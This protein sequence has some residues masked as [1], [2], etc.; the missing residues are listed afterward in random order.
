M[1][2]ASLAAGMAAPRRWTVR[3]AFAI[4]ICPSSSAALAQPATVTRNVNLR[5]DPSTEKAPVRLL[6]PTRMSTAVPAVS[7][8]T[9]PDTVKAVSL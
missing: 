7:W 8:N 3:L 4:A 5:I 6:K 1:T 2:M 9:H